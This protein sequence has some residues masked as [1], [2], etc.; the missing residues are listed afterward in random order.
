MSHRVRPDGDSTVNLA[1]PEPWSWSVAGSDRILQRLSTDAVLPHVWRERAAVLRQC[2]PRPAAG[3]LSLTQRARRQCGSMAID[4]AV[5]LMAL[6]ARCA[7]FRCSYVLRTAQT[8]TYSAR[9]VLRSQ[10]GGTHVHV[11]VHARSG[12]GVF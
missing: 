5:S 1:W 11:H 8:P 3:W 2:T 9:I 7:M 4:L 10:L 6:V 12:H